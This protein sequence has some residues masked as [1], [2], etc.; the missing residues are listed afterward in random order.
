ML[1]LLDP[2]VWLVALALMLGSYGMGR[3][4][5]WRADER[6]VLTQRAESASLARNVER[7]IEGKINDVRNAKDAEL[8][9]VSSERDAA[10]ERVRQRPARL[11]DAARAAC[12]G[13]T[14]REL[15][16]PDA[17]TAIGIAADADAILA[18]L[19]ACEARE[20]VNFEALTRGG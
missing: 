6:E 15:S 20:R 17:R 10:L 3:W 13:A 2:R 9:R 11:P 12:A 19:R 18:H 14:G 1:A 16:E 4:Q 7:E 8:R 5:Q